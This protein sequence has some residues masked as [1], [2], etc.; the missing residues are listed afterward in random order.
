MLKTIHDPQLTKFIGE[1]VSNRV[2]STGEIGFNGAYNSLGVVN[3]DSLI[4]GVVYHDYHP[5]Y[6]TICIQ[7]CAETS[8]WASRRTIEMLGNYPFMEL[9]CQ[10]VTALIN[11]DNVAALRLAKGVGFKEEARLIRAAGDKDIIVLRLFS[12]EWFAGRFYRG[13]YKHGLI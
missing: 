13:E 6:R 11:S 5:I 7:L 10:R 3:N 8:K 9:Q 1:W 12:E 2:T 4:A